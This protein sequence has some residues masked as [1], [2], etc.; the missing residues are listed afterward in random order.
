MEDRAINTLQKPDDKIYC[1][2]VYFFKK[3]QKIIF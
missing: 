3:K 1:D 2:L